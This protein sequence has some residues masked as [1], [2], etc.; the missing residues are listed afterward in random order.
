ML[1]KPDSSWESW[2][3]PSKRRRKRLSKVRVVV[4]NCARRSRRRKKVKKRLKKEK[5]KGRKNKRSRK[6]QKKLSQ[7]FRKLLRTKIKRKGMTSKQPNSWWVVTPR[8]SVQIYSL[9]RTPLEHLFPSWRKTKTMPR[10]ALPQ[11]LM[12]LAKLQLPTNRRHC[13]S[14]PKRKLRR[15]PRLHA[16]QSCELSILVG[17]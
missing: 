9:E 17:R 12:R 10:L 13:S 16:A 15:R 11:E 1:K 7:F 3:S 4:A 5:G 6:T 2:L 8:L 14:K